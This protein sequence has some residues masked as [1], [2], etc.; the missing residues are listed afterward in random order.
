MCATGASSSSTQKKRTQDPLQ[1]PG[2]I[3]NKQVTWYIDTMAHKTIIRRDVAVEAQLKW[4]TKEKEGMA[5]ANC[6]EE[7]GEICVCDIIVDGIRI[8]AEILIVDE[9]V[10]PTILGRPE[11]LCL[12]FQFSFK[13]Q[14][15]WQGWDQL[16]KR[17]KKRELE[18][19]EGIQFD[20]GTDEQ[21]KAVRDILISHS[22][23]VSQWSE[24]LGLFT[25]ECFKIETG[26]ACPK[27]RPLIRLSKEDRQ[28]AKE[29]VEDYLEKG[30]IQES[31][32]A[33]AAPSFF[34]SQKGYD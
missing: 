7:V 33:W 2:I 17:V 13:N 28:L 14:V 6:I 20:G 15:M 8:E 24:S 11:L 9:L 27:A 19:G 26:D 34:C 32:S 12:P 30:Y 31:A 22:E 29:L 18:I 25:E 4:N 10:V 3:G 1:L 5:M 23:A 21:Q 16:N